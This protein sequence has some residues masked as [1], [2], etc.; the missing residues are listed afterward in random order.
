[1]SYYPEQVPR[2]I[3]IPDYPLQRL[4]EDAAYRHPR[5]VATKFFGATLS[6]ADLDREAN[7][8]AHSLITKGIVPGDRVAI[9]LPNCPQFLIC[10]FGTLKAGAIATLASP[11]HERRELAFQLNDSGARVLVTLSRKD[12][13]HKARAA[14]A[15]SRVE[16]L[17]VTSIKDYFSP[18]MRLL[19][20]LFKEKK[21]GHR[22]SL[23]AGEEWFREVIRD[24]A[25]E[26][27]GIRIDP[28]A[29]ALLQYTGGTTG[30]PK[31]AILTH[32]NLVAN[33]LQ[34]RA[35][36]FNL[37]E[38]RERVL[39]V[40]P[41]FH[42]YAI[43]SCMLSISC[44]ASVILL[45]RFELAE[46]LKEI[47][48]ERPTLFPGIPAMYAA[49]NHSLKREKGSRNRKIDLSSIHTCISGADKLPEVV[50]REFEDLSGGRVVEGYGLTE[51]SPVTH[52]NPIEGLRK[53]GSIG[54]PLPNTEV[55]IVDLETGDDLP[56]GEVGEMLVRGPQVMKGYWGHAAESESAF[57]GDG[58]LKTGDMARMDD[59]GF[60]Y[61]ADRKKDLIIT[62]GLNV[63]PREI[64]E[65]L[66]QFH[67][68]KE[69]AVKGLP[70]QLKG[71]IVK[72]YVVLKDNEKAT[73]SEIRRFAQEKLAGYKVPNKIEFRGELPRNILRKVLKRELD[74]EEQPDGNDD[75]GGDTGTRPREEA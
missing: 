14:S 12:V 7:R 16:Q 70:H 46:V 17:V 29:T 49:I 10:L 31:A 5:A 13:L 41:L 44:A 35:W 60:Y 55:R 57:A 71:E 73:A 27:P 25:E 72:A 52:V 54:L 69:V 37:V 61:I 11:L 24:E 38:A 59:D 18:A 8:F 9:H 26:A 67:K 42:V 65:V 6:Y 56:A 66:S 47:E 68:V 20:T 39:M 74:D 34:A 75:A 2:R 28:D 48:K 40:L 53:T 21:E 43:T 30:L 15:G 62:G 22:A 3:T 4:V 50:Q 1:M 45:P 58:W 36:L 63:Y 64:E 51:A 23:E 19:F 32:R 33:A